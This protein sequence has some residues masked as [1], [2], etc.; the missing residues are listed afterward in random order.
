MTGADVDRFN[1][2]VEFGSAKVDALALPTL[3]KFLPQKS[4]EVNVGDGSSMRMWLQKDELKLSFYPRGE[5]VT[6]TFRISQLI[7]PETGELGGLISAWQVL[8]SSHDGKSSVDGSS[9]EVPPDPHE[10]REQS[11]HDVE[12]E[13]QHEHVPEQAEA[14]AGDDKEQ[15]RRV[16]T[17]PVPLS[18]ALLLLWDHIL[19]KNINH[20]PNPK[21]RT[22]IDVTLEI[23]EA[24][25]SKVVEAI[26]KLLREILAAKNVKDEDIP[27]QESKDIYSEDGSLDIYIDRLFVAKNAGLSVS[28][29]EGRDAVLATFVDAQQARASA[30]LHAPGRGVWGEWVDRAT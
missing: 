30:P 3:S 1:I 16:V 8:D 22:E 6:E 4:G 13:G 24:S 12:V 14:I 25:G 19:E 2:V 18:A 20:Y 9:G 28:T 10:V 27:T 23:S 5:G 29:P 15:G 26:K 17:T 7:S 21:E 11:T